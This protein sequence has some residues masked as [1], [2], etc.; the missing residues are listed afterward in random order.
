MWFSAIASS[1]ALLALVVAQVDWLAARSIVDQIEYRWIA[2]GIGLILVE[3]LITAAR[4]RV[5]V[6]TPARFGDCLVAAAWYALAV[7][8]LPA[9]L[10]EVAG[11]A[12]IVRH[13][14]QR[15]GAAAA[16]LLIQRLFDVLLLIVLLTSVCI[17]VFGEA[18]F[19]A[20]LCVGGLIVAS[21]VMMILYLENVLA[22]FARPLLAHRRNRWPRRVL[23]ILLQARTLRRHHI[24]RRRIASLAVC[25]LIKWIA[26]LC[27]IGCVVIAV[28][29]A[30]SAATALGV[31]IVYNLS[32]LIPI[33]TVGGFGISEAVLLA[34]FKWLGYPLSLGAPLAIAVRVVLIS[35]SIVF[36]ALVM[37]M[38][39]C[40]PRMAAGFSHEKT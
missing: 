25:T 29:P 31:G 1:A 4:L 38:T 11:V 21:V 33:Q 28:A 10:G 20:I 30:L 36:W 37:L 12:L 6:R 7:I 23:R 17:L 22:F 13:M 15:A 14:D 8:G 16:S 26:N 5:L 3:G 2:I 35:A 19:V 9:R 24:D 27:A 34:S 18:R 39:N 32:A 40:W